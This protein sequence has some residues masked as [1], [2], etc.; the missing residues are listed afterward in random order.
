MQ[1]WMKHRLEGNDDSSSHLKAA[2]LP[3]EIS[4]PIDEGRLTLG[5]WQG[6]FLVEHRSQAHLRQIEI[7]IMKVE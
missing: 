2:I 7:R 5:T 1:P 3:T 4:I 6:V